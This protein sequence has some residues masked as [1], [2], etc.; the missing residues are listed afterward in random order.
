LG[1]EARRLGWRRSGGPRRWF[2]R[3]VRGLC[4][5]FRLADAGASF[6]VARGVGLHVT[7]GARLIVADRVSLS[8][9]V[10][11]WLDSPE[12]ELSIGSESYVNRR[13]EICCMK[14][15]TI[16]D[17]CAISWDVRITDCDYHKLDGANWIAPVV[18]G[19]DVWIAAGATI[20]KGVTIGDGSVV[21]AG[22][23]V[24]HDVPPR[25]LVAGVPAKVIREDVKWQR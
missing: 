5:R 24:T 19:N 21:A 20:L 9:G 13:S 23:L 3:R 7:K 10:Q 15:V 16:G 2:P 6:Y 8:Q 17:R 14:R 4:Y 18:I 1:D 25:S 22:A 12:A 11:V